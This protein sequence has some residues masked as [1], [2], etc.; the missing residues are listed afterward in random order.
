MHE[1]A[2]PTT[3][4][5]TQARHHDVVN[6]P[7]SVEPRHFREIHPRTKFVRGRCAARCGGGG[8]RKQ[9]LGHGHAP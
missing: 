5:S 6:A 2:A 1:F 9:T 7:S 8:A 3:G 4:H